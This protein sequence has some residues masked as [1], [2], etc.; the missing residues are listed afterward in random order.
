MNEE[1]E[2]IHLESQVEQES[3]IEEPSFVVEESLIE[4]KLKKLLPGLVAQVKSE[5]EE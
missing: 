1:F 3:V 2:K 4:E 5:I